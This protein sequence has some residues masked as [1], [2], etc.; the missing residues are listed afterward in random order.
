M[1]HKA[2]EE[3]ERGAQTDSKLTHVRNKSF[4]KQKWHALNASVFLFQL[5]NSLSKYHYYYYYAEQTAQLIMLRG[6]N[7]NGTQLSKLYK[8]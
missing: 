4:G 7:P 8:H 5:I 2:K 1:S 3:A 6:L